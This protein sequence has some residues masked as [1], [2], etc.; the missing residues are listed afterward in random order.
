[1]SGT[2]VLINLLGGVALLLWGLHM[3]RTGVIRAYGGGIREFLGHSLDNR[4]KALGAG[5]AVTV[6][7]QSSTATCLLAASFAGRGLV[8]TMPAL[9]VLLGADV[10]TS[11]VA[12]ILSFDL[13]LFSPILLVVGIVLFERFS[14]SRLRNIGRI[15]LGLGQMLLALK[16]IVAVSEPMRSAEVAQ[17]LLGS[18]DGEPVLALLI[19]AL[20]TWMAHSSLATVLLVISLST[21]GIVPVPVALALVL[22]ANLGSA[23]P[24]IF[25]TL[26]MPVEARRPPLGN[27]LFRLT[28]CVIVL[29]LLTLVSQWLPLIEADSARQI[30]NFHTAF[31]LF[32]AL[33]FLPLVN[34]MANLTTRILPEV[35]EDEEELG[36]RHLDKSALEAPP[37]ALANAARETVRMGDIL[38]GMFRDCFEAMRTGDKALIKRVEHTDDVVDDFHESIMHYLTELSRE[39]L[40]DDDSRRCTDTMTF[41]TNLE[42]VGDIVVLN[43]VEL[44]RSKIK[45]RV[46][47]AEEDLADLDRLSD[48]IREN[49]RLSFGVFISGDV[50]AARRLL[51]QKT[52]YRDLESAAVEAHMARIRDGRSQLGEASSIYLDL[53][54]DLRRINSHLTSAAYPILDSAGQLRSSRLKKKRVEKPAKKPR[55]DTTE[56]PAATPTPSTA[57][58]S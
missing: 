17:S 29:P 31:N 32:L 54:R 33:L 53:L 41:S 55:D 20:I 45:K 43:L 3:V 38:E 48:H 21:V 36:P 50:E 24:P 22:G 16:L 57:T 23:L 19:G 6:V 14:G 30:A 4:V 5:L 51:A 10:G 7:L 11:L 37:I 40:G 52:V 1:M 13:S 35:S 47:F 15:C 56:K 34:V 12:Q 42:H 26:S 9:A 49:M 18:L 28:G 58:R 2:V 25:A 39:P 46:N 44:V 27:F 8:A